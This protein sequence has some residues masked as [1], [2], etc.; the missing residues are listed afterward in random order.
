MIDLCWIRAAQGTVRWGKELR[1]P[2][3]REQ[4]GPDIIYIY[5]H[6]F[7]NLSLSL[8]THTHTH[9]RGFRSIAQGAPEPSGG[10]NLPRIPALVDDEGQADRA[11]RLR[12]RAAE[13]V[14]LRYSWP[15]KPQRAAYAGLRFVEMGI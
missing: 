5:T 11:R 1:A 15:V 4:E 3:T 14:Q 9:T 6:T 13:M 2:R 7:E 10:A 8:H 12:K